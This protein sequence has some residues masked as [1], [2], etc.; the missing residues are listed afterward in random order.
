MVDGKLYKTDVKSSTTTLTVPAA[1][2]TPD[3][4]VDPNVNLL[5]TFDIGW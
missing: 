4:K 3:I 1:S 5:A 2:A